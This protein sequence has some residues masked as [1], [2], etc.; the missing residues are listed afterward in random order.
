MLLCAPIVMI[1][2]RVDVSLKV[3]GHLHFCEKNRVYIR[4]TDLKNIDIYKHD[5]GCSFCDC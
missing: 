2:Q 1:N 3:P 5:V 4:Q